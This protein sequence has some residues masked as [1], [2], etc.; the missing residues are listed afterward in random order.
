MR[1]LMKYDC[2]PLKVRMQDVP[3]PEP[4]S[5]QVRIRTKAAGICGTD[6]HIYFDDSFPTKPPVILGHELSGVI[7]KTGEGV[8]GV[9]EGMRVTSETYFYTCG[10]CG[11]CRTGRNN[12]CAEKI[13]IGS[14]ANGAFAEYI[15]VPARNIHR[16]PDS[17]SY[18][19]GALIEPLS[20]CVQ[21]VLEKT[22]IKPTDTV[23][24]TGPG[25]IGLL[26]LQLVKQFNARCMVIGAAHDAERLSLAGRL[27]ADLLLFSSEQNIQEAV[28]F[29][30]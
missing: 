26:C 27:G 12:L 19:E 1:A 18:E 10:T 4:V 23:V 17:L 9:S 7:D 3:I 29:H 13:S 15:V 11:Y 14:G 22:T 30:Y 6:V 2:G 8:T 28:I 16:L 25:S 5:G 20:C 21:A 24:I